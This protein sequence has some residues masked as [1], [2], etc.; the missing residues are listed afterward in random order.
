MEVFASVF[1]PNAKC[2]NCQSKF[3]LNRR[4][5]CCICSNRYPEFLFCKKCSIKENHHSLGF[6]APKR[7][8]LNCY[9]S[10]SEGQ[11]KEQ[12]SGTS[13]P[14]KPSVSQRP[15]ENARDVLSKA[16]S[17][18]MEPPERRPASPVLKTLDLGVSASAELRSDEAKAEDRPALPSK[19][20]VS[21][22]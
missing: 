8:C 18:P 17:L 5:K 16:S 15:P 10:A 13:P 1:N 21:S 2:H 22:T 4:R 12:K 7:Y 20:N 6:L 9:T 19:R 14:S 11:R 3:K